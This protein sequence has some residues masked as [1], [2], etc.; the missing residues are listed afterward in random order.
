MDSRDPTQRDVIKIKFQDI[1]DLNA[2]Y[3]VLLYSSLLRQ[4]PI[5]VYFLLYVKETVDMK[6]VG[7]YIKGKNIKKLL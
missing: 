3:L 5:C 6:R 2:S 7:R 4:R 1:T